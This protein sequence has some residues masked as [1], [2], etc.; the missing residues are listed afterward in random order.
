MTL[1]KHLKELRKNRNLSQ[2]EVADV[3]GYKSFT[4]I[5]KWEDGSSLP[6]L[7]RLEELADLYQVGIEALMAQRGIN[8]IPVLGTV[9]GGEPIYASENFESLEIVPDN[10]EDYFYLR[11]VGDSMK[12]ARICDGDI[13]LVHRQNHLQNGEIGVVIIEEEATVKYVYQ[14]GQKLRLVPAN[15]EYKS[16]E[17]SPQQVE[18]LNIKVLGKV[19]ANH[20]QF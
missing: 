15:S 16:K 10:P 19:V 14:K 13:I 7:K 5:Q 6:P 17:Y 4:T 20:I 2:Q 3:L 11:V 12:E 1:H 18:S 9:R 8:S